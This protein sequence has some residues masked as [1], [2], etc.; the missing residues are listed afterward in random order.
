MLHPQ[1]PHGR[2]APVRATRMEVLEVGARTVARE[3]EAIAWSQ[4]PGRALGAAAEAH[5]GAGGK[6]EGRG[7]VCRQG[8][9]PPFICTGQVQLSERAAA[10]AGAVCEARGRWRL[11]LQ[12]VPRVLALLSGRTPW[13]RWLWSGR[14]LRWQRPSITN[15]TLAS[16][17]GHPALPLASYADHAWDGPDGYRAGA[18][19]GMAP[20]IPSLDLQV[21][22]GILEAVAGEEKVKARHCAIR[23]GRAT[24]IRGIVALK[25]LLVRLLGVCGPGPKDPHRSLLGALYH[26]THLHPA[27]LVRVGHVGKAGPL[28]LADWRRVVRVGAHHGRRRT[29]LDA[30][31]ILPGED[32]PIASLSPPVRPGIPEDPIEGIGGHAQGP[33]RCG[34]T[35]THDNHGVAAHVGVVVPG[36][37]IASDAGAAGPEAHEDIGHGKSYVDRPCLEDVPLHIEDGRLRCEAVTSG[38]ELEEHLRSRQLCAGIL[39]QVAPGELGRYVVRGDT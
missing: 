13:R 19:V 30:L 16:E 22:R 2:I 1:V 27:Q 34:E 9:S 3:E 39:V 29:L 20:A 24:V 7:I 12:G 11:R 14:R 18:G 36:V 10:A 21:E 33:L 15:T 28:P 5:C 25:I 35:P 4:S 26:Q 38:A 6:A 37:N 31:H 17:L 8:L 32:L 23:Q